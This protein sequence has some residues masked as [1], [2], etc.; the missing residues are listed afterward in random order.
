MS[1]DE[2]E[3]FENLVETT[4]DAIVELADIDSSGYKIDEHL[5][6]NSDHKVTK[7]IVYIYS[8]ESF[9]YR[10]LNSS[11]R[12]QDMSKVSTMGPF[13]VLLTQIVYGCEERRLRSSTVTKTEVVK[14]LGKDIKHIYRGLRLT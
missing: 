3:A 5:L 13:A 8:M 14:T 2:K 11:S 6:C 7:T 9:V 12:N 10:I 1:K 4:W